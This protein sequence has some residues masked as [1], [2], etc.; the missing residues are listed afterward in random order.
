MFD[1]VELLY[2]K[3]ARDLCLEI[4]SSDD[5]TGM[6]VPSV[7][8][9][10]KEKQVNANTVQKA[11]QYLDDLGIFISEKGLGRYVSDDKDKIDE[12][13]KY[14]V[15]VELL[16]VKKISEQFKIDNDTLLKWYNELEVD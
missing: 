4:L 6:K 12:I 2:V 3:I 11:Y 16:G 1:K 15:Q 7:R 14:L 5:P 13:K 9:F 8:E 10:S